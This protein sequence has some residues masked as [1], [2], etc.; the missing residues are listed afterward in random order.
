MSWIDTQPQYTNDRTIARAKEDFLAALTRRYSVA[1]AAVAVGVS[2]GTVYNWLESDAD[3]SAA[4]AQARAAS[5]ELLEG[6]IHQRAV[7]GVEKPVY[8]SGKRVLDID[9]EGNATPATITEY[10]DTLLIFAAKARLREK[11]GDKLDVS[12]HGMVAK[13]YHG[14]NLTAILQPAPE[15]PAGELPPP[16]NQS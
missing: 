5:D 6:T 10:S 3:F 4:F 15:E 2:R 8:Q 12:H 16:S 7:Y 1:S 11:Y 9:D 14:V 13:A